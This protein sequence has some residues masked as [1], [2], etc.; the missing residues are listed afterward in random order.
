[1]PP[2]SAAFAAA[3]RAVR[4]RSAKSSAST[5]DGSMV[6]RY[7]T[8]SRVT[9]SPTPMAL[10]A[11]RSLETRICS[12]FIGSTGSVDSDHNR[13]TSM[14][15]GMV[16]P[17]LRRSWASRARSAVPGSFTGAPSTQTSIGP[18]SLYRTSS[19]AVPIRESTFIVLRG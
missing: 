3:A 10:R 11:R 5:V 9:T 7:P 13:S 17:G 18:S 8:P 15:A 19:T 1:M 4:M 16:R 14:V 2:L 6:A 12:A